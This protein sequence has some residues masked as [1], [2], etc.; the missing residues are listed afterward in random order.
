MTTN[1]SLSVENLDRAAFQYLQGKFFDDE[2]RVYKIILDVFKDHLSDDE[3]FRMKWNSSKSAEDFKN[4]ADEME[5]KRYD[6]SEILHA[7]ARHFELKENENLEDLESYFKASE[8]YKKLHRKLYGGLTTGPFLGT[9]YFLKGL[10]H[11]KSAIYEGLLSKTG[12]E[13]LKTAIGNIR[14]SIE[15]SDWAFREPIY[16]SIYTTIYELITFPP[17]KINKAEVAKKIRIAK[18]LS[19]EYGES[20]GE[21]IVDYLESLIRAVFDDDNISAIRYLKNIDF[22][23]TKLEGRSGEIIKQIVPILGWEKA[24]SIELTESIRRPL[25]KKELK[26]V[27]YKCKKERNRQKKGKLLED[28]FVKLFERVENFILVDKRLNTV[29]EE[30]DIVFRNNVD[31]PFWISLN[32]PHIIIECKNWNNK[33]QAEVIRSFETKMINH[34]NLTKIGIFVAASG[35]ESGCFVEQVRGGRGENVIVL[36]SGNEIDK[37]LESSQDTIEWMEQLISSCIR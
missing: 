34:I 4:L 16:L 28:F 31:K 33:I 14:K 8:Y 18:F 36:I 30:L 3:T 21:I 26:E 19:W 5:K 20:V 1:P 35:Y 22:E 23:I 7:R 10:G 27:W 25:D 9:S 13:H 32:S 24:K 2:K 11:A 12:K 15:V 29:N 6:E 37:F 17:E